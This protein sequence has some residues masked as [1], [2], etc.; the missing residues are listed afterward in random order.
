MSYFTQMV[1]LAVQNFVCAAS[2]MAVMVA[3]IRGI[4]RKT[5][6]TLG[7]FWVDLVRTT[8]YVLLPLSIVLALFF[9]SQGAVQTFAGAHHVALLQGGEQVIAIGPVASQEAIKQLG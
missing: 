5:T 2:G 6:A 3:L 9:V 1:A 7:N 8:L 4:A